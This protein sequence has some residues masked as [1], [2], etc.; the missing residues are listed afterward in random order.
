MAE[1]RGTK[2]EHFLVG[3]PEDGLLY[4][5]GGAN[6]SDEAWRHRGAL[7]WGVWEPQRDGSSIL[8]AV[9]SSRG[10]AEGLL[11]M[12]G[13]GRCVVS[14]SRPSSSAVH[15]GF[16]DRMRRRDKLLQAAERKMA[17][18]H[19]KRWPFL[20]EKYM[21]E[22]ARILDGALNREDLLEK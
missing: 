12:P 14:Q 3:R 5:N 18:H 2:E 9:A 10:D 19:G 13:Y 1:L 7:S 17:A 8:M 22:Y 11:D 16:A 21:K 20:R 4:V 6:V 15:G